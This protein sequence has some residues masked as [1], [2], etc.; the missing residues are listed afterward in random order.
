MVVRGLSLLK[1][2]QS[3]PCWLWMRMTKTWMMNLSRHL[4][5]LV[6]ASL[7]FSLNSCNHSLSINL[8]SNKSCLSVLMCF[9]C[10]ILILLYNNLLI[11]LIVILYNQIIH[12]HIFIKPQRSPGSQVVQRHLFVKLMLKKFVIRNFFSNTLLFSPL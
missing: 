5:T 2:L 4:L 6:S 12:N 1:V 11:L 10:T 7:L 8:F 3:P 9:C